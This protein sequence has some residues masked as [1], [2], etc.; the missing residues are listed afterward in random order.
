MSERHAP[1]LGPLRV[2]DGPATL[3]LVWV[4]PGSLADHPRNWRTHPESQARLVDDTIRR[5]GWAETL[6][7]NLRTQRLIN[8]HLRKKLAVEDSSLGPV[9]VLVGEWTEEQES[10][11]LSR[12]DAT[13]EMAT[14]DL[15]LL[16]QVVLA[17]E[18][19]TPD[20]PKSLHLMMQRFAERKG[21]DFG[22]DDGPG[23][24]GPKPGGGGAAPEV[25]IESLAAKWGTAPGQLWGLRSGVKGLAHFY[26]IGDAT[27]PADV[28]RLSRGVKFDMVATSPPYDLTQRAYDDHSTATDWDALMRGA[29]ASAARHVADHAQVLVNLGIRHEGGE[30]VDYWRD[31]CRWMSSAGWRKFGWYVWDQRVSLPGN[32]RGHLAPCHE[33]IFHFNK[34]VREPNR[35]KVNR[36][37]GDVNRAY[38]PRQSSQGEK[39]GRDRYPREFMTPDLGIPGSIFRAPRGYS[40]GVANLHPAVASPDLFRQMI[41]IYS[42]EGESIYDPFGG[43]GTTIRAADESHRNASAMEVSPRYAAVALEY[44]S[45][46]D[47]SPE[48]IN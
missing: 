41:A 12:L 11:I 37:A 45:E 24:D 8:G 2:V 16:R 13:T 22:D 14:V 30:W 17:Q 7:Y 43:A 29:F 46:H 44:L 35:V 48:L 1:D 4:D 15:D 18:D 5:V 33:F 42:A 32:F 31:F 28:A 20:A 23:G 47:L 36:T 38:G 27:N 10:I 21:V 39:R 25:T 3:R 40:Q 9:P 6:L 26:M 19:A 34:Q